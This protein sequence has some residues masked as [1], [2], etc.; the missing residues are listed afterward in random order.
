MQT[1]KKL[2]ELASKIICA[3]YS[4]IVDAAFLKHE[5][6]EPFQSLASHLG[7]SY[8]IMEVTAP[9]EVLRQRI[10]KRKN[11]VSDAD[12]TVLEHQ[13]TSWQALQKDEIN[14]AV[15]INTTEALHIDELIDIIKTK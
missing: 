13:L 11:D 14:S 12:L 1:Y 7:I 3:G 8:I 15:S 5:Q 6:R 9:A 4:V 10:I 2:A